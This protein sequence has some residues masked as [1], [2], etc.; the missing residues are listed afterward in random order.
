MFTGCLAPGAQHCC[1]SHQ[2]TLRRDRLT[3]IGTVAADPALDPMQGGFHWGHLV[4]V[5]L[6]LRTAKVREQARRR[7]VLAV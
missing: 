6:R 4:D 3:A 7:L 5:A 1:G 2:P